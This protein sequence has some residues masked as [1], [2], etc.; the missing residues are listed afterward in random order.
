MPGIVLHKN[1]RTSP[2]IRYE[3]MHSKLSG[4]ELARKYNISLVTVYKWKNRD[5]VNDRSHKRH[6][7]LSSLTTT[8]EEIV[9]ELREK[10]SLSVDELV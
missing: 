9:K 2:A 4:T 8:E 5:N 6:N 1:A 7:L 3:I 10:A